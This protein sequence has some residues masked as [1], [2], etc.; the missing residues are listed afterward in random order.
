MTPRPL[1]LRCSFHLAL[2]PA[3]RLDRLVVHGSFADIT[4]PASAAV[5]DA[6]ASTLAR[7]AAACCVEA[8]TLRIAMPPLDLRPP[9]SLCAL[10]LLRALCC[11]G[12][13]WTE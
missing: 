11:E 8:Q 6:Q 7:Q 9:R 13:T 2:P 5:V 3:L 4:S 1:A 12:A 10:D